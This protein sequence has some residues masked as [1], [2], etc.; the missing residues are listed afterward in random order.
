MERRQKAT[1]DALVPRLLHADYRAKVEEFKKVRIIQDSSILDSTRLE[2][3]MVIE[4]QRG[5]SLFGIPLY[6]GNSLVHPLDPPNYETESGKP[7][8]DFELFPLPDLSWRWTWDKWRVLMIGDLDEQGWS[9]AYTRFRSHRWR[10]IYRVN[11]FI[12]RRL[13]IRERI[14]EDSNLIEKDL[15]DS[16]ITQN[17]ESIK[18]TKSPVDTESGFPADLF[19]LLEDC[20]IDRERTELL[21]RTVLEKTKGD[22]TILQNYYDFVQKIVDKTFVFN[23]SKKLFWDQ[24]ASVHHI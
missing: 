14:Q 19:E 12:R 18:K 11:N 16:M 8:N 13:W 10:G 4:N 17:L 9:Y 3:D 22:K 6:G 24:L 23:N 5:I 21:L 15:T 1:Q 20:K 2:Y 7:V